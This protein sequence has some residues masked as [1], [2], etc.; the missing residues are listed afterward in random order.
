M[1]LVSCLTPSKFAIA[2]SRRELQHKLVVL[3][4]QSASFARSGMMADMASAR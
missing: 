1:F 2:S 4:V 3:L